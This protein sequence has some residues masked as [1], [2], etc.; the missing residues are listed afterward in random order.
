VQRDMSRTRKILPKGQDWLIERMQKLEEAS[1]YFRVDGAAHPDDKIK[2]EILV[3]LME[4]SYIKREIIIRI[5]LKGRI[6]LLIV[7][8]LIL[9]LLYALAV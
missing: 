4:L 8:L 3:F 2:L 6:F 9:L 1:S 5:Y 7:G